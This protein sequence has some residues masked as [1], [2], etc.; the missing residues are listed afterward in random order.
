MKLTQGLHKHILN[1]PKEYKFGHYLCHAYLHIHLFLSSVESV[2]TNLI[3]TYTRLHKTKIFI[4]LILVIS[5]VWWIFPVI[6]TN[7]GR[8]HAVHYNQVWMCLPVNWQLRLGWYWGN[9]FKN[10]TK[11]IFNLTSVFMKLSGHSQHFARHAKRFVYKNLPKLWTL[12]LTN[13]KNRVNGTS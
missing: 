10:T 5:T 7:F 12:L 11:W 1:K 4:W 9:S 13:P 8:S 2:I 3:I 6:T